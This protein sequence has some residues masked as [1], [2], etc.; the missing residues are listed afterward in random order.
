MA[1]S[2][3]AEELNLYW[4]LK[5][6]LRL[7]LSAPAPQ[8]LGCWRAERIITVQRHSAVVLSNGPIKSHSLVSSLHR[9]HPRKTDT[10]G[11]GMLKARQVKLS[12]LSTAIAQHPDC[13]PIEGEV[14]EGGLQHL[15]L[16]GS[17]ASVRCFYTV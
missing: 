15:P 4:S 11:D 6:S 17:P 1:L 10:C 14:F 13:F 3:S 2:C 12:S 8:E 7:R 5:T 16:S 9:R